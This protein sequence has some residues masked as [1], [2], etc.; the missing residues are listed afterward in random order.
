[1][2]IYNSLTSVGNKFKTMFNPDHNPTSHDKKA[3]DL[4]NAAKMEEFVDHFN[5]NKVN[6]NIQIPTNG[7]NLLTK[8]VEIA[9][10]TGRRN[11]TGCSDE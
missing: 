7:L 8:A 5:N 1:M 3:F 6:I 2:F 11:N 9:N 4:L 10:K